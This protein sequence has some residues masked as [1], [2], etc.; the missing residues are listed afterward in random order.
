MYNLNIGIQMQV[1]MYIKIA[2]SVFIMIYYHF[3]AKSYICDFETNM[4]FTQD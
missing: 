4:S 2:V 3:L 1:K